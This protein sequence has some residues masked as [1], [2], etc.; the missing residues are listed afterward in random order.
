[1]IPARP[2]STDGSR[3]RLRS[4][5]PTGWLFG[6]L[7]MCFAVLPHLTLAATMMRMP[8]PGPAGH[9][10]STQAPSGEQAH[11]SAPCHE[12]GAT[13]A[14]VSAGPACCII[15]CGLIAEAPA[16][17][18]LPVAVRWSRLPPASAM[19]V[20]DRST[21]PAERPPRSVRFA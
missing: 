13:K 16:A 6:M 4:G 18:M 5:R 8:G 12:A 17:A 1:M 11:H 3:R 15:G 2:E 20:Q 14:P 9:P 21:E 19:V 7:V 10:A